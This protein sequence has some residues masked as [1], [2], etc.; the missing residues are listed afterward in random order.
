MRNILTAA[1]FVIALFAP[2]V[3]AADNHPDIVCVTD[4]SGRFLALERDGNSPDLTGRITGPERHGYVTVFEYLGE[5][6][7]LRKLYERELLTKRIPLGRA[8]SSD[9]RFFLTIDDFQSSGISPFT[10]VIYD[11]ARQEHTA[12]AGKDFLSKELIKSLSHQGFVRGFKWRGKDGLFNLNN[13]KFYPTL[14]SNCEDEGV[15]FVVIDLP[16]RTVRVE[17]AP[18]KDPQDIV[19]RVDQKWGWLESRE[20]V[21]TD[22]TILPVRVT[23]SSPDSPNQVFELA[24]DMTEYVPVMENDRKE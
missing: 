8:L 22:K 2:A 10:V 17:P 5:G 16:T 18:A 7:S 4:E 11:L 15:P 20:T 13:T 19:E 1:A 6:K 23:R 21:T 9:G 24:P 14:P 12:Y 3:P